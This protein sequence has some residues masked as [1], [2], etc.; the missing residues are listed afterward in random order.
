MIS[1]LAF[2]GEHSA[3]WLDDS[4]RLETTVQSRFDCLVMP[5]RSGV[6]ANPRAE[7]QDPLSHLAKE[8]TA[9]ISVGF[10][11]WVVRSLRSVDARVFLGVYTFALIDVRARA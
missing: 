11:G 3:L 2:Y 6:P 1:S 9:N 4:L 10:R 5:L 8:Y 7:Q